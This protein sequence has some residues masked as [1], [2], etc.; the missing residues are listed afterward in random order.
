M[1]GTPLKCAMLFWVVPITCLLMSLE[2]YLYRSISFMKK[3]LLIAFCALFLGITSSYAQLQTGSA[4]FEFKG[5]PNYN[6]GEVP[7]GP[8]VYH[9]FEFTNTGTVPLVI[10]DCNP[11]CSCTE[12]KW[13]KEPILPGKTGVINVGFKTKGHPGA[14]EKQ[15]R[16]KSNAKNPPNGDAT[17]YMLYISGTVKV[18]LKVDSSVVPSH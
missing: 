1:R 10:E 15:I 13:P 11:S 7:E 18:A 8:E 9:D 2:L 6:F 5:G 4:F 14:F 16:I 3:N 17:R 12:P